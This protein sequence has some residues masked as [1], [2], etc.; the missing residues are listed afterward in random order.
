MYQGDSAI[1]KKVFINL[2]FLPVFLLFTACSFQISGEKNN[3]ISHNPLKPGTVIESGNQLSN[4][5][6]DMAD[7]Y[8]EYIKVN[9]INH[10]KPEFSVSSISAAPI[11]CNDISEVPAS[12]G[13]LTSEYA[14]AFCYEYKSWK[15]VQEAREDDYLFMDGCRMPVFVS[16]LLEKEGEL[17]HISS[18]AKLA[19]MFTPI[20]TP[21]KALSFAQAAT[22]LSAYY[23][24]QYKKGIRYLSETIEDSFA[25]EKKDGFKVLLYDYQIC[26]CGPHTTRAVEVLVSQ[27]GEISFG[28]DFPMFEDPEEDDLCVD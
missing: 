17:T 21:E 20:D 5:D 10:P 13:G 27:N 4:G 9:F 18:R 8:F 11:G 24:Q 23:D 6:V 14:M 16:L 12:M 7:P 2:L 26:G 28:E 3:G 22:G 15:E 1:M 25:E 19:D